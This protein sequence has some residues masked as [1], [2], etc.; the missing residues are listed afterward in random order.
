M[1]NVIQKITV[2]AL[3]T[4]LFVQPADAMMNQVGSNWFNV[5]KN[6]VNPKTAG[7]IGLGIAGFVG[8]GLWMG[9]SELDQKKTEEEQNYENNENNT[10]I[11]MQIHDLSG[12]LEEFKELCKE[13]GVQFY[14]SKYILSDVGTKLF[15]I[16]KSVNTEQKNQENEFMYL[17][18]W[19]DKKSS[20]YAKIDGK[21]V[22]LLIMNDKHDKNIEV[23]SDSYEHASSLAQS[24]NKCMVNKNEEIENTEIE[25]FYVFKFSVQ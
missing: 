20:K 18:R 17:M 4:A 16:W 19:S 15:E 24:I 2:V 21:I 1:K 10:N 11:H 6:N 5:I 8:F 25:K 7:I 23:I 3:L 22:A 13:D 14:N 9:N 12:A